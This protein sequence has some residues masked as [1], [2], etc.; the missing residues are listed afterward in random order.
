LRAADPQR[1]AQRFQRIPAL[2]HRL[3][4]SVRVGGVFR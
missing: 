4:L 2:R 1:A 3:V